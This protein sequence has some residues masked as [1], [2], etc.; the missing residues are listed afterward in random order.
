M[1]NKPE[2]IVIII[3]MVL[4]M[5]FALIHIQQKQQLAT[6]QH[7]VPSYTELQERLVYHGYLEPNDVDGD[8]GGPDSVTR[9][10]WGRYTGDWFAAQLGD[11]R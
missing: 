7:Y 1:N 9:T 4:G 8:I 6:A 11:M 2:I 5:G 10:A 3:L